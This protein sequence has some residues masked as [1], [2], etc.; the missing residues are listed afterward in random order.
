VILYAAAAETGVLELPA[1][2]GPVAEGCYYRVAADD[3]GPP[4]RPHVPAGAAGRDL[5]ARGGACLVDLAARAA[6]GDGGF[7]LLPREL[8]ADG[9][10]PA[11]L[12]CTTCDFRGVCRVEEL[13]LPPGTARKLDKL[14][15][16]KERS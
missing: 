16:R 12:P 1:G 7:P 4:S 14:V 11:R 5:L 8:A 13:V 2:A 9:D 10:A 3:P 15:N 6:R